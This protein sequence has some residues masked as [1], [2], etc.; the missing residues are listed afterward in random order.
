MNDLT[1]NS[2]TILCDF[3]GVLCEL[4]R[5]NALGILEQ[6]NTY[7]R[8][9]PTT[10]L[11]EYFYSNPYYREIDLGILK[12][13]DMLK[14]ICTKCWLGSVSS[15]IKLWEEIWDCYEVNQPLLDCFNS[16]L[17]MGHSVAIVTDNH[18]DFRKWLAIHPLLSHMERRLICSAEISLCKPNQE[19]F[20]RAL[21]LTSNIPQ[22]ACFIDDNIKNVEAAN[23]IGIE[24]ILYIETHQAV[25]AVW[26]F[27]ETRNQ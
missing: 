27:L 10:L 18:I 5:R 14:R 21:T 11:D 1:A 15:W 20:H 4:N 16:S 7:L 26:T 17:E 23:A 25:H 3:D 19:F 9:S 12:Y 8:I 13:A 24:G 2:K 22:Q 6:V